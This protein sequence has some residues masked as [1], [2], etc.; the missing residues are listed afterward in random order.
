MKRDPWPTLAPGL[1]WLALWFGVPLLLV[2]A[3][4]LMPSGLYG[5]VDRGFTFEHYLRLADPLYLRIVWRSVVIA[6]LAT[7]LC[8]G[9]GYPMAYLIV[10]SGRWR[11]WLLLLV[12]LPFWTSFLVRTYAMIFLLRDTG[13]VNGILMG[14]GVTDAPLT[15]LYTPG[16]VLAGLV[17]GFLPFAVLPIYASLEK[18]DP[19]LLEASELLGAPPAAGFWRVT[20]PLSLPGVIAGGLLVFI[21]ALG[22]F[23]TPDL[24]GG[25]KSSLLGNLVQDQFTAARNWPFG[26]ALSMLL[27]VGTF[28]ALIWHLRRRDGETG[29]VA[30]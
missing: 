28:A 25:A 15:L 20:F 17:Y 24:M 13:L 19:T 8:L 5:G 4:S 7:A 12:V 14:L 23:L 30:R 2:S 29:P 10:Q 3:Y 11:R 22:S 1:L 18:V 16:A 6:A 21:P 27:I 9:I 26:S